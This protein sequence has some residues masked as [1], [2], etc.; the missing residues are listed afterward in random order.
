[1]A[2]DH[3]QMVLKIIISDVR[4]AGT[5]GGSEIDRDL[6]GFFEAN[7]GQDPLSRCHPAILSHAVLP[8]F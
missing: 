1:M 7:A 6:V 2:N 8:N 4:D 3:T 5:G